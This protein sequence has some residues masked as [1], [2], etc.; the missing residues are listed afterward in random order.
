MGA[1]KK[2]NQQDV[3]VTSYTAKKSW[4][5]SSGSLDTY[6]IQVLQANSSSTATFYLSDENTYSGS[7]VGDGQYP[8]L[9]Y[10]SLSHLY[11]KNHNTSSGLLEVSSSYENF[12]ESSL[13]TGSRALGN[14]AMVYSIPRSKYGNRVEPGTFRFGEESHPAL[15]LY[16]D[17]EGVIRAS[18]ITGSQVG[19]IIYS[20]GQAII[21][22]TVQEG[23]YRVNPQQDVSWKSNVDIYTYN[24]T[25]R[26]SDY[27]YNFTQNPTA[28]TGSDNSLRDNITGSY[29]QPYITTVGLYNDSNELIAV[30]KLSKPLPK[31]KNTE[32]TI[33][34]KL[35]I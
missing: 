12:L 5:A 27:E 3:Y 31:S 15:E 6:G 10:R 16:D 20:H 28:L 14:N 9:V 18:S 2:L 29:F 8:S 24:Y 4:S 34:V 19:T 21:T 25:V 22:E 1:W 11:F 35:D 17:G 26:L 23:Y 33:Q 32:T 7:D 13:A 30:A